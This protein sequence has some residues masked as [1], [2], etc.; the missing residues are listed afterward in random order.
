MLGAIAGDIIGSVY[1]R[2]RSCQEE[3]NPHFDPLFATKARFT[4]D[5]VLTIA[6][7]DQILH[8]G[9]L[10]DLLK[11]YARSYPDAGY[12][13]TFL[14]WSIS[15]DSQPYGSWGNGSA[16]RGRPAGFSLHHL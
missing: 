16:M 14:R 2:K 5:S 9:D 12:G 1:E 6:V 3:K 7:A 15:E 8:G 10:V 13:G 4:D 11:D